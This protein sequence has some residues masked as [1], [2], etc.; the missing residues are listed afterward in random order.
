MSYVIDLRNY[1][2]EC[3]PVQYQ[4][5]CHYLDEISKTLFFESVEN[6]N[7]LFTMNIYNEINVH[8]KKRHLKL[9]KQRKV[10]KQ[11]TLNIIDPVKAFSLIND[12]ICNDKQLNIFS[13]CK[14]FTYDPLGMTRK[15]KEKIGH[16][17]TLLDLNPQNCVI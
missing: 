13:Y 9:V 17:V 11:N 12:N 7:G 8:A 6:N 4:H 1:F 16:S 2:I 10:K 3:K 15:N 14:V 5:L